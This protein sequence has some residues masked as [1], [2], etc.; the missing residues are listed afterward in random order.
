MELE[1]KILL[2]YHKRMKEVYV[3]R[4]ANW[5]GKEDLL[6]DQGIKAAKDKAG[7]FPQFNIVHSSP[8]VRTRQTAEILGKET[9]VGISPSASIPQAPDE[10]REQILARR[11][12]HPLGIAGAL[13]EEQK[14]H[15]ST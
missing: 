4:H 3:L 7:S 2:C 12:T 11:G 10:I 6:T 8:F 13:F 1:T 5:D 9:E 14:A 15:F